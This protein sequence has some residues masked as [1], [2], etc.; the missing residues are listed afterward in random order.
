MCP[1]EKLL[2]NLSSSGFHRYVLVIY[3]H[4]SS[5]KEI[6]ERTGPLCQKLYKQVGV[7]MSI[8]VHIDMSHIM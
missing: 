2:L 1:S 8:Y 7:C 3:L 4:C 6:S 5:K